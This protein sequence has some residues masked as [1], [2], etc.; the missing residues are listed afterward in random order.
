MTDPETISYVLLGVPAFG[1]VVYWSVTLYHIIRTVRHLPTARSGI[2]MADRTPVEGNVVV[3][4]PA[5]NEADVIE[6]LVE[7]LREQ[8]HPDLR[9]VLALDR[10]TDRTAEVAHRAVGHDRRFAIIEIEHC[11]EDWAGKVH[12]IW[13]GLQRSGW[14]EDSDYLLFADADTI[15]DPACVRATLAIMR[16]RELDMLSLL[17]TLTND[18][19]YELV[20]QTAAGWELLQQYP[21]ERANRDSGRRAFANGQFMAFRREAYLAVGGHP[22]VR[23]ALLEDLALAR[24][25]EDEKLR[26]GVLLADGMLRCRMYRSYRDF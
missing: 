20:A 10:C 1:M 26:T 2:A 19:W 11:P 6:G 15:F 18:R 16:E 4:V 3:V 23:D 9:V 13:E 21:L 14:F 25:V 8:D 5:H 12:A 17:S 24:L 7:S 22:S